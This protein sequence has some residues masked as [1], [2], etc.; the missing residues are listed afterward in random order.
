MFAGDIAIMSTG[1]WRHQNWWRQALLTVSPRL[2]A[3]GSK[4][5]RIKEAEAEEKHKPVLQCLL[6]Q[7]CFVTGTTIAGAKIV[8]HNGKLGVPLLLQG[9]WIWVPSFQG[10][11]LSIITG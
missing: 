11:V 3:F 7:A 5:P 8:L 1:L 6:L 4:S 9:M 10:C 2:C